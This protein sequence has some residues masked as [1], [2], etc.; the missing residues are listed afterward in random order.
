M[1]DR[2]IVL[3]EEHLHPCCATCAHWDRMEQEEASHIGLC[4]NVPKEGSAT[5]KRGNI[6]GS[7]MV[8][9]GHVAAGM[10]G[11]TVAIPGG[12]APVTTDMTVCSKWKQ[13]DAE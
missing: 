13:K 7:N 8:P 1:T 2:H 4:W 11:Q 3:E 10:F 5:T 12:F 9:I 6:L